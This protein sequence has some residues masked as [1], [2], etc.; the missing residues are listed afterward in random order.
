LDAAKLGVGN[1]K[2]LLI[3]VT[4]KRSA[5]EIEALVKLLAGCV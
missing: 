5:A 2:Q 3:A 1:A 4:E